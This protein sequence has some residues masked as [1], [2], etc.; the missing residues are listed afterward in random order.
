ML[1]LG[2][3]LLVLAALFGVPVLW[4]I[5]WIVAGF[6]LL[7]VILGMLDRSIGPYRYYY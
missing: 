5:G 1:T 4:T 2:V 6:G 3:V 7:L